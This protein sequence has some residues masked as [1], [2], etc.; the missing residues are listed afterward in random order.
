MI[1]C[2]SVSHLIYELDALQKHVVLVVLVHHPLIN[3]VPRL[4]CWMIC[5][6]IQM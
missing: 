2:V 3:E 6:E 1:G 5:R 4:Q